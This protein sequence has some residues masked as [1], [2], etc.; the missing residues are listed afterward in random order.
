MKPLPV[1]RRSPFSA[2]VLNDAESILAPETEDGL[3][4]HKLPFRGRAGAGRSPG[5]RDE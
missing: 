1:K 5:A 3:A 4:G 2:I